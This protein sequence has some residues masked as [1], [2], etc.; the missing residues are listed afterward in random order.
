EHPVVVLVPEGESVSR[1]HDEVALADDDA[2]VALWNGFQKF[3]RLVNQVLRVAAVHG[4]E[5]VA[6]LLLQLPEHFQRRGVGPLVRR[7]ALP[8]GRDLPRVS[9]PTT[10]HQY[11]GTLR[12]PPD[13]SLP[14][15]PPV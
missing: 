13:S 10:S 14:P 6:V 7:G 3:Q 11:R 2:F 8:V 12:S 5:D 4:P 9:Q 15:R 1:R